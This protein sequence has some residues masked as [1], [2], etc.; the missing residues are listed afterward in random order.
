MHHG[1]HWPREGRK[2]GRREGEGGREGGRERA[3]E[4]G[5][6]SEANSQRQQS[7]V[8]EQPGPAPIGTSYASVPS[9]TAEAAR[10]GGRTPL[11]FLEAGGWATIQGER[12]LEVTRLTFATLHLQLLVFGLVEED[13]P[14][15]HDAHQHLQHVRQGNPQLGQA[16]L[17]QRGKELPQFCKCPSVP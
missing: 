6:R 5:W 16:R 14:N 10:P 7:R 13:V 8:R 1:H 9:V 15:E 11:A 17:G 12:L 3:G 2:E 4:S